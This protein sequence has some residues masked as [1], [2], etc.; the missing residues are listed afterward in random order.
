LAEHAGALENWGHRDA[1]R[2]PA[3]HPADEIFAIEEEETP[4]PII[5][6]SKGQ[7]RVRRRLLGGVSEEIV[8]QATGNVVLVPPPRAV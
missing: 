4:S 3:S 2:G 5:G 7:S 1:D 8:A 6:G